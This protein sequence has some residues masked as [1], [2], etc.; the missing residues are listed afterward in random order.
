MNEARLGSDQT[1]VVNEIFPTDFCQLLSKTKAQKLILTFMSSPSLSM[2]SD[3]FFTIWF[4]IV[5]RPGI[6]DLFNSFLR[7][8]NTFW[9][10]GDCT[11]FMDYSK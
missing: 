1:S 6:S 5:E 10:L 9:S 4:H 8:K 3:N 11:M 7:M 2:Y